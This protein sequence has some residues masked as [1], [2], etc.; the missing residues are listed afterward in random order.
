MK[1]NVVYDDFLTADNKQII[2]NIQVNVSDNVSVQLI[3][4]VIT[5]VTPEEDQNVCDLKIKDSVG[6]NEIN[7]QLD[8]EDLKELIEIIKKMY[9]EL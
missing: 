8:K 6:L 5:G 1:V 2:N 9:N 7:T 3:K 4:N